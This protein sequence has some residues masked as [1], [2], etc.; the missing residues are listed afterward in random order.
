MDI[1]SHGLWSGAAYKAINL[2]IVK[3]KNP[4]SV[5]WSI[6]WG[7]FPDFFAFTGLF[8]WLFVNVVLGNRNFSNIPHPENAEPAQQ[9]TFFIFRLTNILYNFSHSLA[10]F[11]IVFGF[12]YLIFKRPIWEMGAWFLH[13]LIDI[14]THSYKFYPTPFLWP[15]SHIKF[16]GFSWSSPWFLFADYFL[17]ALV[18]LYLFLR[19]RKSAKEIIS[20]DNILL[21]F[22]VFIIGLHYLKVIPDGLDKT[23]LLAVSVIATL[24]VIGS[25]YTSLKNRKV[26]VDLLASVAL[27]FSL[28]AG[29]YASAVFINLMLTSARIFSDYSDNRARR[30][31]ESLLK[32]KPKKAKI[33]VGDKLLEISIEDIRKGDSVVVGLGDLVPVDGVVIEGEANIDQSSLTGESISVMKGA[34]DEVLSSTIVVSGSLTIKVEKIGKETTLEKIIALVEKSQANKAHINMI[35]DRFVGWYISLSFIGAAILYFI[36]GSLPLVLSVLLVVCADDIAVAIPLAFLI[37]IGYAAKRGVIIKGYNFL[38]GMSKLRIVVVDKTGTLTK[39][40][41]KVVDVFSFGGKSQEEILTLGAVAFNVSSHPISKSVIRYMKSKGL[42]IDRPDSFEE[43]GGRGAHALYKGKQIAIGN[44]PFLEKLKFKITQDQSDIISRQEDKGLNMTLIGC[45]DELIGFIA[46]E[47]EL[48]PEVKDSINEL[49]NL[50]VEK[51]VMLTGDNEKVAKRVAEAVGIDEFYANLLPENK[52]DHLK[53][54]LSKDYRTAMIGDGVNDA[55]VLGLADIGIAMGAIGSDAAIESADI[56]LM[57]DDFSRV[58]EMV[59]LSKYVLNISR[60]NF[61]VWGIVNAIGLF[62]VFGGVFGPTRAA[63]YNFVTDFIP[64]A[65]AARLLKLHLGSKIK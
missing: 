3:N 34:G 42:P 22:L 14:P 9:D 53:K 11:L 61:I 27:V 1:L 57:K 28:I 45:G 64:L 31:I 43:H 6:F 21:V 44:R 51:V 23:V 35:A 50:G 2:K 29:E 48:R 62:L 46:L 18:Y 65:N 63:A 25:A 7:V 59:K 13:I 55:A 41:L 49:K 32:L 24:P 4:L 47:S 33:K 56:V 30:A 5:K 54:Y 8:V 36:F 15:F 26:T 39:G 37:A 17:L 10:I 12:F 52:L 20:F 60:Q 38:E 40:D 16:N 58:P 19:K